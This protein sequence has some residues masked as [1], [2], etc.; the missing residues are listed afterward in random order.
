MRRERPEGTTALFLRAGSR[1]RT[2]SARWRRQV[3]NWR[4]PWRGRPISPAT[5]SSSSW[6][7]APAASPARFWRPGWRGRRLVVVERDPTLAAAL[8]LWFPGV[9]V[10]RGDAAELRALL[11]P[12]GIERAATVVSSLPLLSMPK[13]VRLRIVAEAFALLGERGTFVQFTYGVSSPLGP[14]YGLLGNVAQR[15]WWNFPPAVVWRFRRRPA[16]ARAA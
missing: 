14:E 9:K 16:I 3:G 15:V 8:R 5:A 11:L 6:A 1:R 12:L 4:A 13:R 10:L 2:G 7:A